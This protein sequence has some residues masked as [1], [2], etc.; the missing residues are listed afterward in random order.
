MIYNTPVPDE[1]EVGIWLTVDADHRGERGVYTIAYG[2]D[3]ESAILI[4]REIW[5]LWVMVE[6]FY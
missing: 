2:I 1:P 4:S 3:Q 6:H 5:L